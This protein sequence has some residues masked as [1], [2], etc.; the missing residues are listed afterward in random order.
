MVQA[1]VQEITLQQHYLSEKK[2]E[3]IYFGGGTPSLLNESE[4]NRIF[5]SI[6]KIY[7][8]SDTAEITL[9][10]NPDDL[11]KAQLNVLRRSPINRLSIGV[12]SFHE[13][14]LQFMNRAHTASEATYCIKAAQDTGFPNLTIDLIFGLPDL[15]AVRWQKNLDIFR[16]LGIPHLS[17]YGLTVEEGTALHHFIKTGKTAPLDDEQSATQYEQLMDF[18]EKHGFDHYEISN[19]ARPG[20][21]AQHNTAYWNGIPYLGVGPSAHSY[22]GTSRQWNVAHNAQYLKAIQAGQVPF[23][24]EALTPDIR[25]NEYVMTRLRTKWGVPLSELQKM[26]NRFLETFLG[27][28]KTPLGKG[29]VALEK[30]QYV[31][32]RAGKLMADRIAAD[33]M[34]S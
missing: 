19:F 30:D 21:L 29:W 18:A 3:S 6:Y 4:L 12:Q 23:E 25:Y 11:T 31:L 13:Q 22:N 34:V 17:C 10:A 5:E 32:T 28:I 33:L 24:R 9:E 1:I 27:G 20:H 7:N 2:L 8:I 26:D 15:T 14:D 16:S